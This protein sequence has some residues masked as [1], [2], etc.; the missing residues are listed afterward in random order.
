MLE[1]ARLFGLADISV[2]TLLI[3]AAWSKILAPSATLSALGAALSRF[4]L[5]S[6]LYVAVGI[7]FIV[8]LEGLLAGLLILQFRRRLIRGSV[9]FVF[10]MFSAYLVGRDVLGIRQS[11]GCF[12]GFAPSEGLLWPLLRNGSI[13]GVMLAGAFWPPQRSS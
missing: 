7:A 13:A 1:P 12:G 3:W 9:C 6:G 5:L 8:A 10:L 4:G 11:C 2:A